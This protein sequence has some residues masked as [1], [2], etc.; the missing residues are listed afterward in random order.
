MTNSETRRELER[1]IRALIPSE[2]TATRSMKGQKASGAAA[3]FGGLKSPSRPQEPRELML[4]RLLRFAIASSIVRG[5][6]QKSPTWFSIAGALLLF[7]F[8]DARAA[9]AAHVKRGRA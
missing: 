2:L 5:M 6:I 9:K 7:R 1:S 8:V 3:G 4:R